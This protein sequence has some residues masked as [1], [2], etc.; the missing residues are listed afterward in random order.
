ML[1][2]YR[3]SDFRQGYNAKSKIA[4]VANE[5]ESVTSE[6]EIRNQTNIMIELLEDNL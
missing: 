3:Y 5:K 2:A 6:Q 4:I 1:N